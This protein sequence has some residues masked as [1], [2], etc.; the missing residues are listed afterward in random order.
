LNSSNPLSFLKDK[1]YGKKI[2][3]SW[4]MRINQMIHYLMIHGRFIKSNEEIFLFNHYN[5][6]WKI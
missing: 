4:T 3:I 2:D 6:I 1:G 5:K